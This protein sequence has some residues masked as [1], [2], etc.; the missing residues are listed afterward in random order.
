M[1]FGSP[2]FL[3]SSGD[4]SIYPSGAVSGKS[5]VLN[6]YAFDTNTNR[7]GATNSY[8]SVNY[9]SFFERQF[10][11]TT[12]SNSN[13]ACTYSFW[14][15]KNQDTF[16]KSETNRHQCVVTSVSDIS[17][18]YTDDITNNYLTILF[19]DK[20]RLVVRQSKINGAKTTISKYASEM[21]FRDY[22]A[23]YHI[24]VAI[25]CDA[26]SSS[27][28]LKVYVNG[29]QISMELAPSSSSSNLVFEGF[30][31]SSDSSQLQRKVLSTSTSSTRRF[32]EI[33]GMNS[34]PSAVENQN[35]SQGSHD[36]YNAAFLMANLSEFHC[37]DGQALDAS[38]FGKFVRNVWV[39]IEY[40]GTYGN[41][42]YQLKFDHD[43]TD[44]GFYLYYKSNGIIDT[45][46]NDH[47]FNSRNIRERDFSPSNP[48]NTFCTLN[49][50]DVRHSGGSRFLRNDN[51]YLRT[52]IGRSS[53]ISGFGAKGTMGASSGKWYWEVSSDYSMSD[54]RSAS[55]GISASGQV[56]FTRPW[57]SG[58][59]YAQVPAEQQKYLMVDGWGYMTYPKGDDD[60]RYRDRALPYNGNGQASVEGTIFMIA[61][62]LDE[63]LIHFGKNGAWYTPA[64]IDTDPTFNSSATEAVIHSY[65]AFTPTLNSFTASFILPEGYEKILW[66]PFVNHYS[67]YSVYPES[68]FNFGQ[69]PT[70]G[71]NQSSGTTYADENGYGEFYYK[72]PTG[73]KAW[74]TQ[75]L[76]VGEGVD[77]ALNNS[78]IDYFDAKI[79]NDSNEY[80]SG[81]FNEISVPLGIKS[82]GYEYFLTKSLSY[83]YPWAAFGS[84]IGLAPVPSSDSYYNQYYHPNRRDNETPDG[85]NFAFTVSGVT[86]HFATLDFSENAV[87]LRDLT[88]SP[89]YPSNSSDNRI[90]YQWSLSSTT[91]PVVPQKALTY[92]GNDSGSRLI[93]HGLGVEPDFMIFHNKDHGAA[94]IT[95]NRYTGFAVWYNNSFTP[96]TSD[97]L[98]DAL[99]VSEEY[100][101]SL[102]GFRT[103]SGYDNGGFIDYQNTDF[104]SG[105]TEN[106]FTVSHGA[107]TGGVNG[108]NGGGSRIGSGA[109]ESL[110]VNGNE[111]FVQLFANY[112]GYFR[113]G[114]YEAN[115]N[116]YGVFVYTGFRPAW[117]LIKAP[118]SSYNT[119]F[120]IVDQKTADSPDHNFNHYATASFGWTNSLTGR[121]SVGSPTSTFGE[122][123][124][125]IFK[126][127]SIVLG[128]QVLIMSNGFMVMNK[129]NSMNET[130]ELNKY[131]YVHTYAAFADQPYKYANA[132]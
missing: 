54:G 81:N 114:Y 20:Q 36:P 46:G 123:D 122:H 74:C 109:L 103:E 120:H 66:Q 51:T 21:V 106:R 43:F 10:T 89:V 112:D 19:D 73:F 9:S 29:Y 98:I 99:N 59:T 75:N 56:N 45:S 92:T 52:K 72:V 76:P 41:T 17:F 25:D 65:S 11:E 38:D 3:Y 101:V 117:V 97:D 77:I 40:T 32:H 67:A 64:R 42:G 23:W 104:L 63:G 8:G 90:M 116:E 131:S 95:Y 50:N 79:Y 102:R 18:T 7:T 47:H 49:T 128:A 33:I 2:Q 26:S 53:N 129:R 113:A 87:E 62:D 4:A 13:D 119:F 125:L 28:R 5:L 37:I 124:D 83:S 1:A 96:T 71:G 110:N 121:P 58:T 22:S 14:I 57:Q 69:N 15:K 107:T 48:T 55:Y 24:V 115:G 86:T 35:S 108:F 130:T 88:G 68:N 44:S 27:D 34:F 30:G 31:E 94:S 118:H 60:G 132:F 105:I 91:S 111:Y 12:S 39:P 82:S 85:E 80:V 100:L 6:S 78:P 126:D 84:N 93:T 127:S 70:F 16:N 61:L